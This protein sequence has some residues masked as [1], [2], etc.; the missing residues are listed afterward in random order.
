MAA[1]EAGG[2]A[3]AATATSAA[4]AAAAS[5]PSAAATTTAAAAAATRD[6][7]EAGANVLF[8]EEMERGETDVGH[9]LFAKNEALIGRGIIRLRDTSSGHRGCGCTTNQRKTQSGGT[10]YLHG[11]GF[12]CAFLLRSLLDPWHGRILCKFF[13]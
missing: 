13:L 12:G 8:V 3:A 11:G 9:F 10:Q 5:A 4:S 6:L 2:I 7:L 1:A